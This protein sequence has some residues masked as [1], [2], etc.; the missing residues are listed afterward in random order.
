[1]EKLKDIDNLFEVDFRSQIRARE[2]LEKLHAEIKQ[3]LL[4]E[5]VPEDIRTNFVSACNTLLYSWFAY[6][7]STTAL[8]HAISTLEYALKKRICIQNKK[9][10]GLNKLLRQAEE[11]GLIHDGVFRHSFPEKTKRFIESI[12]QIR[13]ELMHGT[14]FL[15]DQGQILP[16]FRNISEVINCLFLEGKVEN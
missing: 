16:F 11:K 3:C 5:V 2:G 1:M 10:L 14:S 6:A 12:S 7:I 9:N 8:I 13:N 15:T 4:D